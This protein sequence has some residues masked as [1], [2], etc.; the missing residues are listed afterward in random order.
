M[1]NLDT[2]VVS[3][4][5]STLTNIST[6]A[7]ETYADSITSNS[8]NLKKLKTGEF[9]SITWWESSMQVDTDGSGRKLKDGSHQCILTLE[10][11]YL[12][13]SN[14]NR[15]YLKDEDG[16]YVLQDGNKIYAREYFNAETI[17]YIVLPVYNNNDVNLGD[18]G[19]VIDPVSGNYVYVIYADRGP[20]GEIGESSIAVHQALGLPFVIVDGTTYSSLPYNIDSAN[21]IKFSGSSKKFIHI[22]FPGEG[23]YIPG[24]YSTSH[25]PTSQDIANSVKNSFHNLV[26]DYTGFQVND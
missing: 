20:Q 19:V 24:P 4:L 14:G 7:G 25:L 13:D 26:Y 16:N 22:M 23:P 10:G 12:K 5:L 1:L 21:I 9:S 8:V 15:Y 6:Y 17:P 11:P 18:A 3:S 2:N